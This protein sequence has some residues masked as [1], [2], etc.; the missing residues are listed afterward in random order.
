MNEKVLVIDDTE[1]IVSLFK[2]FLLRQG[3]DISTAYSYH[4]AMA[5]MGNIEFDLVLTDIDLGEDKSGIDI[6]KEVKRTNPACPV[7]LC[8]GNPDILTMSEARRIGAYDCMY[9][10]VNLETLSHRIN[11]ALGNKTVSDIL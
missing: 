7:I 4:G 10:P 11:S 2:R 5:K 9:K 1:I 6:L 3:Y 8:T